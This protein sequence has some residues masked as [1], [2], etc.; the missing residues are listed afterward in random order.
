MPMAH[1]RSKIWLRRPATN[2]LDIAIVDPVTAL[3]AWVLVH[4]EIIVRQGQVVGRGG[5]VAT[6]AAGAPFVREAGLT[7]L[8]AEPEWVLNPAATT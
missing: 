1:S 6:T 2:R 3:P 7:P 5:R 8:I 4:G